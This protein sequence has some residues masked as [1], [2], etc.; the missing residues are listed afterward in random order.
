MNCPTWLSVVCNRVELWVAWEF[1]PAYWV[2][3]LDHQ[4]G[5]SC[6]HCASWTGDGTCDDCGA[7]THTEQV[8]EIEDECC[9]I[10]FCSNCDRTHLP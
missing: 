2:R 5:L 10:E 7:V 3:H 8:D 9:V 4:P 6:P 1:D